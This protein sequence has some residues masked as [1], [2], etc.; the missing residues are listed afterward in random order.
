LIEGLTVQ[1]TVP[2]L[3]EYR[4]YTVLLQMATVIPVATVQKK[5]RQDGKNPVINTVPVQNSILC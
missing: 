3:S 1:L 5:T 4:T 2:V